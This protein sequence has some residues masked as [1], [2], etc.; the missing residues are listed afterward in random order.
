MTAKHARNERLLYIM[1]KDADP[2]SQVASAWYLG[3]QYREVGEVPKAI[4]EFRQA[5]YSNIPSE[6]RLYSLLLLA[7]TAAEIGEGAYAGELYQ[8]LL[9]SNPGAVEA[10]LGMAELYAR[11]GEWEKGEKHLKIAQENRIRILPWKEEVWES[12]IQ[13]LFMASRA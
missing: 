1:K 6:Y 7:R 13:A 11:A 2:E 9:G 3:M 10:S 12:A 4:E 5:S 8:V